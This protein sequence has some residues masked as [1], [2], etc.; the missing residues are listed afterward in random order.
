MNWLDSMQN[1]L[2]TVSLYTWQYINK[3]TLTEMELSVLCIYQEEAMSQTASKGRMLR[4][5]PN[6][7]RCCRNMQGGGVMIVQACAP[8]ER[9]CCALASC[10]WAGRRD[11]QEVRWENLTL[12]LSSGDDC[13]NNLLFQRAYI[14]PDI[15]THCIANPQFPWQ[16]ETKEKSI[17]KIV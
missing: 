15:F 7:A 12:N 3:T 4:Y 14:K 9:V 11:W 5:H 17:V 2:L 13:G 16:W 6:V 1:K 10:G 8:W